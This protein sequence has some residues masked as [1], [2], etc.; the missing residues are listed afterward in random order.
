MTT[1]ADGRVRMEFIIPTRGLVGYR[2]QLLTETRGTALL[3]Q[4]GAGYG[5][6]A[7]E[8]THRTSGVLV[9]DRSGRV[10]R[11]WPVQPAGAL[12]AAD[13]VGRRGLRGHDRRREQ[14]AG[15]HG[16]QPDQGKEADQHPHALARRGAAPDA[17][18]A[19]DARESAI[20][21]IAADELVEVTP[22][23]LRLRKRMLSMHDRRREAGRVYDEKRRQGA[24]V[25]C[26]DGGS[27]PPPRVQSAR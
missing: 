20:E 14:P 18:A 15:R 10:E 5:P 22:L 24:E 13:R 12:G 6:W 11:L 19:A 4:I 9:S 16:R 17:A 25:A 21:F 2:G 26:V 7:G 8:V 27:E 1:D 23:N 3:H